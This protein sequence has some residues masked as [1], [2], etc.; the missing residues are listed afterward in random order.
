[1]I[2]RRITEHV[3]AQNWFAV[4]ID[5]LIVVVGVFIG[6]QVTNWNEARRDAIAESAMLARLH[7]EFTQLEPGL[8]D[9]FELAETS[10]ESTAIVIDA[11]R[12]E[13]PPDDETRF[14]FALARANWVALN[15]PAA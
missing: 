12:A 10:V 3:L 5:F 4:G 9:W 6:I 1:M 11:L 14:R 2:L 8:R 7:E 15:D 13:S